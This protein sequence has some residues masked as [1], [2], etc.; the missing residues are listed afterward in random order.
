LWKERGETCL[1][2]LLGDFS[3]GMWDVAQ[4]TLFCARDF[5]G[6]GCPAFS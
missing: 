3:F 2:E 4:K 6:R 1:P 5:V